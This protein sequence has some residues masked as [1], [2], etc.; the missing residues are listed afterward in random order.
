MDLS[1]APANTFCSAMEN[2]VEFCSPCADVA[3][4]ASAD[5]A[6]DVSADVA[7]GVSA[8]VGLAASTPSRPHSLDWHSRAPSAGGDEPSSS[9]APSGADKA[10][11]PTVRSAG[12]DVSASR[13]DCRDADVSESA[14]KS[15][16]SVA[17]VC[18]SVGGAGGTLLPVGV[19]VGG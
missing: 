3:F 12:A 11:P 16:W 10:P 9:K 13:A 7:S 8:G 17:G 5:V 4:C 18:W 14:F 19:E 15:D 2:A 1:M 6:F